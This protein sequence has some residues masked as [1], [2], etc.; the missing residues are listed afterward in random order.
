[1]ALSR[2]VAT[3]AWNGATSTGASGGATGQGKVALFGIPVTRVA[4]FV[5]NAS[6]GGITATIQ[7]SVG[8]ATGWADIHTFAGSESSGTQ[9]V[10]STQEFV[11]DKAR[12]NIS[13]NTTT[14]DLE[15]WLAGA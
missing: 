1:M 7:G 15:I 12:V 9:I 10:N 2:P 5:T 13:D 8:G 11:I 4:A 6:T 14:G 3:R